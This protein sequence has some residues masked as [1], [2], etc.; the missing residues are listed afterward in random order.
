MSAVSTQKEAEDRAKKEKAKAKS[1]AK[2]PGGAGPGMPL[3]HA[4][5]Y[6]NLVG[7]VSLFAPTKH[8][9]VDAKDDGQ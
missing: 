1:A 6:R 7:M 3:V 8:D 2:R 5:S 9:G 4:I